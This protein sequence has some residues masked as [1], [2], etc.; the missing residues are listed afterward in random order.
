MRSEIALPI[1]GLVLL[2]LGLVPLLG[3]SVHVE[4]PAPVAA[5]PVGRSVM[6]VDT[7]TPTEAPVVDG[8]SPA[9]S[10]VL[11]SRG[12]L[13]TVDGTESEG[14]LPAS[15]VAVLMERG[16]VLPVAVEP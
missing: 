12:F 2:V 9:I 7:V 11:H 15:V 8:I 6:T 1:V 13:G 16:A 14:E 10:R 5:E 3:R 4:Q